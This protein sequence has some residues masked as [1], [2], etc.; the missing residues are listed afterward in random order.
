[1][2]DDARYVIAA[3]S[4]STSVIVDNL[5]P[6]T[7]YGFAVRAENAAGN[8]EFGPETTFRTLGEGRDHL[9]GEMKRGYLQRRKPLR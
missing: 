3:P 9:S 6:F 5:S 1:M 7:L 4:N 8:S 2:S